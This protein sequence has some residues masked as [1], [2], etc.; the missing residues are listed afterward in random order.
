MLCYIDLFAGC[1]GLSLGLCNSGW[2][3]LFAV[4]KNADAFNTLS[5]NLIDKENHFAWPDWLSK[6]PHDIYEVINSHKKELIKLRGRVPLV[7]GGPPCQGFSLA[8]LREADDARNELFSA[9]LSFVKLVCPDTLLFENVH[10]FTVAFS[11]NKGNKGKP[12]SDRIASLLKEMGYKSS[13]RLIDMSQY[14]VPQKRSRFIL[15]ASKAFDPED[16]FKRL[17]DNRISFLANKGLEI[18]VS[19]ENAIGDLL[20][21]NGT[22]PC[23]DTKGFKS[24]RYGEARTAYQRLMREGLPANA[25]PDSH[26]FVN[27]RKETTKLFKKLSDS[28]EVAKRYTP[29]SFNGLKKRGVTVTKAESVCPTITS[30]PDDIV[31]YCEPRIPTVREAARIQSFPDR[32]VFKGKYTTGGKRRKNEVPRYTQVA[33]AVPPLFAEQA[34]LILKELTKKD[35]DTSLQN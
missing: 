21:S 8:G 17:N 11:D 33:N 35:G 27:H 24:G 7:V 10:G 28:T 31:H 34:G 14:G 9:Y 22:K 26:R 15:V 30:I 23:P 19:I 25:E 4:E 20:M 3:G 6:E 2:E 12:Y 16:F 18:P 13:S 5:S 1:G 32:Y 29:Q